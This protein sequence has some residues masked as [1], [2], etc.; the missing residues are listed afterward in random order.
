MSLLCEHWQRA[1]FHLVYGVVRKFEEAF[2]SG[3]NSLCSGALPEK[4]KQLIAVAIAHV[5]QR[6]SIWVAFECVLVPLMLV[7]PLLWMKWR[8]IELSADIRQSLEVSGL[9]IF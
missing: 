5:T 1:F 9:F 6:P 8:N 3:V 4:T 2:G 7:Q